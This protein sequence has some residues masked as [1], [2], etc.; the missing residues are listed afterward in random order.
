MKKN[1][2]TCEICKHDLIT[3]NRDEGT[4]PMIVGCD[5]EG[6]DGLSR[7]HFYNVDQALEP[8]SIF[9]DPKSTTEW[10][11]VEDE[12][13]RDIKTKNPKKKERKV[14]KMKSDFMLR[15]RDHVKRGGIVLLPKKIVDDLPKNNLTIIK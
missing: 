11:A 2:Y 15:I 4:T 3:G 7:S 12:L 13:V 9:I 6:C 10:Q 14:Q 5:Q 8:V 1:I